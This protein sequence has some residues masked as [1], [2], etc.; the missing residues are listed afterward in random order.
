MLC[1]KGDRKMGFKIT[2]DFI[3]GK[4]EQGAVGTV[5][6]KPAH[7]FQAFLGVDMDDE[8]YEYNGGKTKVRLMD[9]EGRVHHHAFVD[10]TDMSCELLLRWGANYSG[11]TNVDM[12]LNDY[13]NRFGVPKY[14]KLISKCGNW[15]QL[16]G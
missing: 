12:H 1:S 2:R 14:E 7:I 9:D 16:M 5:S 4:G 15:Y 13:R 11:S 8:R 6:L 3:K 10:D